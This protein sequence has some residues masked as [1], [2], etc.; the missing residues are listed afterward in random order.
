ASA[1]TRRLDG[2]DLVAVLA[3]PGRGFVSAVLGAL[4]AGAG[5]LPLDVRSPQAVLTEMLAGSGADCV[6]VDPEHRALGERSAG[7]AEVLVLDGA[8]DPAGELAGLRGDADGL[9]YVLYTSGS[10]G[11]PKGTMVDRRGMVNHMWAKI[12]DVGL[13]RGDTLVQNGPLTFDVS[14]W[15]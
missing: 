1:L 6:V 13:G 8:Q 12:G 10:T 2:A 15:Q 4:G 11:K 9:A 7:A 14:V 3:A 5:Y